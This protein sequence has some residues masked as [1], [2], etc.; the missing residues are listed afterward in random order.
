[1]IYPFLGLSLKGMTW[2]QGES[3]ANDPN[4]YMCQF[5][6]MILDYRTK[7][8]NDKLSFYFVQLAPY[9][10]G[11][12]LP[13]FRIAQT[14]VLSLPG[15]GMGTAIDTWDPDSPTGEIHPRNKQIPAIRMSL[16][17]QY[18]DYGLNVDPFGPILAQ[19]TV[20]EAGSFWESTL[21]F[22]S[23]ALRLS[24]T[25]KCTTCCNTSPF[26]VQTPNG[27]TLIQQAT[28]SGNVVRLLTPIANGKP[29]GVRYAWF[30]IPQCA[31]YDTNNLVAAPFSNNF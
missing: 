19:I 17:A 24:G 31:L 26:E 4:R 8:Q 9:N 21:T 14:A 20:T 7:F 28:V 15:V 10:G 6:Q 18:L 13:T 11:G 22:D 27:W 5:T 30:D 23:T 1:M 12:L 2:Y 3:N 29:I 25:E 16:A